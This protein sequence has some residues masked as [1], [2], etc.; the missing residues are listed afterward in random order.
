MAV[1]EALGEGQ[2]WLDGRTYRIEGRVSRELATRFAP[3][4]VVG[5]YT[6]ES[7]PLV[8]TAT[9]RSWDGGFGLEAIQGQDDFNKT[10]LSYKCR[11]MLQSI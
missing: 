8:S 6:D 4:T 7:N 1:P 2:V 9:W 5:D 10:K 11:D 3:K